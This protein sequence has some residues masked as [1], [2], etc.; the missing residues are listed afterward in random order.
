VKKAHLHLC[1]TNILQRGWTKTPQRGN[2]TLRKTQ[3]VEGLKSQEE[4]GVGGPGGEEFNSES[5]NVLG[6]A[7]VLNRAENYGMKPGKSRKGKRNSILCQK[8]PAPKKQQ[9]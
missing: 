5:G 2:E 7:Q 3:N 6:P 8:R 4:T 1:G 9:L